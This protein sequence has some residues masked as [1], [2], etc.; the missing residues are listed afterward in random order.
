MNM[1]MV[2][3]EQEEAEKLC[4]YEPGTMSMWKVVEIPMRLDVNPYDLGPEDIAAFIE[5]IRLVRIEAMSQGFVLSE[6]LPLGFS[7]RLQ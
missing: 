3:V 7:H 2:P 1:L 5:M 4:G 6:E